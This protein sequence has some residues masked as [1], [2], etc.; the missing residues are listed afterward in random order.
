[1]PTTQESNNVTYRKKKRSDKYLFAAGRTVP[2]IRT[3]FPGWKPPFMIPTYG[4][5][6]KKV[7]ICT[8]F[9]G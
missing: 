6:Y 7:Y 2:W 1:M 3:I 4:I 5:L 9:L 8:I